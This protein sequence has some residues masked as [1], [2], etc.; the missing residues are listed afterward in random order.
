MRLT[1][2]YTIWIGLT[3]TDGHEK[4]SKF[5]SYSADGGFQ[6]VSENVG[7]D[8]ILIYLCSKAYGDVSKQK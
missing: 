5:L 2:L 1:I 4:N 7:P 3:A 6:V 8:K